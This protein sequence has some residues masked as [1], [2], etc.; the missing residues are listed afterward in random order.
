MN[1]QSTLDNDKKTYRR[2]RR[3]IGYLGIFLPVLLVCFS[4]IPLFKTSV[5]PSISEYYYSNLREIFT[6]TVC[7]IG[8]FLI[9]YVGFKSSS[10]WKNDNVLTNVAG[11][12]AIG[13]AFIPTNPTSWSEKIYTLLPYNIEFL[14]YLH[15]AFASLLFILLSY[16][17]IKIFTIGQDA[18]QNTSQSLLNENNIYRTCGYFMLALLVL[19]PI[20][21]YMDVFSYSTLTFEALMLFAFGISWLVK[22]RVLGDK[23]EI[24]E[25]LYREDN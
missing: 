17:S 1:Q 8:L 2:I 24:G 12:L 18:D 16:I 4:L 6:G 25:K 22:G 5:Q 7:A 13:V 10:F 20:F 9:R 11:Y 14:G 19:T 21:S 15:Y 3:A 23:G